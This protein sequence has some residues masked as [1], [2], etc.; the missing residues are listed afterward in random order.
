MEEQVVLCP[1]TTTPRME[2][3]CWHFLGK[4]VQPLWEGVYGTLDATHSRLR[5]GA[6][7]QA[8]RRLHT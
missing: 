4:T 3:A 7:V 1:S 8:Q 6:L 5:F 2:R